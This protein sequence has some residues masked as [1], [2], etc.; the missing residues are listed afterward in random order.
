MNLLITGVRSAIGKEICKEIEKEHNIIGWTRSAA[1]IKNKA[2]R[3]Q[4]VDLFE[5]DLPEIDDPIDIII[6]IAAETPGSDYIYDTKKKLRFQRIN[7]EAT[8][9]LIEI[10][11][12]KK[13]KQI[14]YISTHAV[15]DFMDDKGLI[16][17]AYAKSKWQAEE[18]IK[19]SGINYTIFRPSGIYGD[20][21][22]WR[23][24]LSQL[25]TTKKIILKGDAS[26]KLQYINVKD[27]VHSI[28]ISLNNS[29]AFNKLFRI[30][31]GDIISKFKYYQILKVY[32]SSSFKIIKIPYFLIY[33]ILSILSFCS[34]HYKKTFKNVRHS[35]K[36]LTV[37]NS[38]VNEYLDY[39]P[40]TFIEGIKDVKIK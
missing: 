23:N 15:D 26:Q 16:V 18:L 27:F 31:G 19:D 22:Y 10:A 3:V 24:Y 6:H 37:N 33:G 30:G 17:N 2:I 21:P 4:E 25:K 8:Q 7:V 14:I 39:A 40:R 13:I 35:R 12:H 1:K 9:R 34:Q 38:L 36:D 11:K 32:T 29:N 5:N 28:I 20:T